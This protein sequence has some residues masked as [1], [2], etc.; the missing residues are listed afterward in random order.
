MAAYNGSRYIADQITSILVQLSPNDE[1]VVVNDAS[2]DETLSIVAAFQ[3]RDR[4]IMLL[5]NEANLGVFD[6]FERALRHCQGEI[7]FLSDQDD[8]W[9]EGKV[10][11]MMGVF[12]ANPKVTLVLSDAQVI[13]GDGD[14][15][16]KSFFQG[17]GSFR[18]SMLATLMKNKYLGCTMAFRR[19]MLDAILPFPKDIPMHDIWIGL[20]NS[21][22]GKACFIDTPLTAYRRHGGNVSPGRRRDL[23]QILRWRWSL[24]KNLIYLI[25]KRRK[26]KAALPV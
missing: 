8:L 22:Y 18:G 25:M 5:N 23:M 2:S 10:P 9:L 14:V 17:R 11:S 1:L 19:E 21:V 16:A 15:I 12:E 26:A 20:V 4:R 7:V 6:S 24:I 3:E 13:N